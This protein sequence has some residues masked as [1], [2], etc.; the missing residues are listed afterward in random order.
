MANLA[1]F[2]NIIG[3][4]IQVEGFCA[5]IVAPKP[6][7]SALRSG[8]G[9]R[10]ASRDIALPDVLKQQAGSTVR[11]LYYKYNV[12]VTRWNQQSHFPLHFS[13]FTHIYTSPPINFTSS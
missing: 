11:A 7:M 13:S 9:G 12:V 8:M 10:V 5:A 3:S 1:R 6:I 4:G 2:P